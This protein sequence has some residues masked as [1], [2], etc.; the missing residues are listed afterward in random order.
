MTPLKKTEVSHFLRHVSCIQHSAIQVN[1]PLVHGRFCNSVFCSSKHWEYQWICFATNK[2]IRNPLSLEF[3]LIDETH[4]PKSLGISE[5]ST[6][7][8]TQSQC[9]GG[10]PNGHMTM[11]SV[12]WHGSEREG[13][14]KP[15]SQGRGSEPW[16]HTQSQA[17]ASKQ[18]VPGPQ[19]QRFW[20]NA[21]E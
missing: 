2:L 12:P 17:G 15:F 7:S 14:V 13:H 21:S 4:L 6:L 11:A 16:V 3:S 20:F 1:I 18:Q 8:V 9:W 5:S 10:L 19:H